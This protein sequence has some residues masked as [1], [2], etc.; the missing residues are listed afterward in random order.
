LL[1]QRMTRFALPAVPSPARE[2]ALLCVATCLALVAVPLALGGIG[3]GADAFNHQVYLGWTADAPRFGRDLFGASGQSYQFPYLYWPL[4]KLVQLQ[5]P[6]M[7]AGV[8][9]AA[10]NVLVVPALWMVARVAIP[11]ADWYGLAMRWLGVGLAFMTAVVLSHLDSTANDLLAGIPLVWSV[12]FALQPFDGRSRTPGQTA[13]LM[14]LS[15]LA[16]GMSVA[17]KLSNGPLAIVLPCLWL[18]PGPGLRARVAHLLVGSACALAGFVL[19]Y[20][21]WGW[22]VFSL[23]GN[24][25]YPFYDQLF[26]GLRMGAGR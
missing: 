8:L 11:D 26:E 2:L 6:G 24:P 23:L 16:A 17:F 20:G 3:L 18:L 5:V 1:F 14:A 21:S 4:Y 25:V 7:W 10:L 9:L 13:W 19:C 15:G 12:A 22:Q